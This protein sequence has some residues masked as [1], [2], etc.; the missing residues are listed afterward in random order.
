MSNEMSGLRFYP[1]QRAGQLIADTTGSEVN[2]WWCLNVVSH[3]LLKHGAAEAFARWRVHLWSPALL[4][5][6]QK[7]AM[8]I[9]LGYRPTD[10]D[11]SRLV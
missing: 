11:A 3:H 4:P 7:P 8:R 5:S 1:F 10:M 9:R 6:E 2:L